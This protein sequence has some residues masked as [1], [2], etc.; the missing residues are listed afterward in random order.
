VTSAEIA[1]DSSMLAV[2]FSNSVI[3]VWSIVPL[4]LRAM[5]SA[6]LLSDIDKE[7]EDV[8]VRMMDDKSAE[9]SKMLFGHHGPVYSMSFSPD[10]NLLLSSSEDTTSKPINALQGSV[11]FFTGY[12]LLE[13][14]P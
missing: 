4:K 12:I 2:G 11:K 14:S 6:E 8:L 13:I 1:E 7:A 5:K 3:K 9:T 10:R